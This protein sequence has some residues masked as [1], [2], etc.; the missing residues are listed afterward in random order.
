M[1]I[2]IT[3]VNI[4]DRFKEQYSKYVKKELEENRFRSYD[5]LELQVKGIRKYLPYIENIFIVVSELEQVQGLDLSDCKIITHDQIIPQKYLPCF[6]S[7]T[8]EM[9]LHKIPG[10]NEQFLYFNDDMFIIDN[11]PYSY[12]FKDNKPCLSPQ[13]Y[14]FDKENNINTFNTRC[15]NSTQ[16]AASNLK[17][18]NKYKDKLIKQAHCP[19]PYLKSTCERVFNK[20]ILYI[21]NSLT[22][23]RHSK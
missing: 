22:R 13:I 19:K 16:L 8:I 7:C 21:F 10:L 3:Y 1:D 4:T 23:T 2:V 9:F 20:N 5:T 11:V 17:L 12:W 6:N 18:S 14:D 15:Y